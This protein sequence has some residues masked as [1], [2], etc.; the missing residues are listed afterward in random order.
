MNTKDKS[1]RR[2]LDEKRLEDALICLLGSTRRNKRVKNLLEVAQA[3]TVAQEILGSRRAVAK[4]VDLSDEM[5][6]NFAKRRF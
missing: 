2:P 4:Q 5:L 3:L 6:R 1:S